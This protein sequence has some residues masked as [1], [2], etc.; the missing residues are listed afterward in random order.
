MDAKG[1]VT[2]PSHCQGNIRESSH[3]QTV[4]GAKVGKQCEFPFIYRN[5]EYT[6][7]TAFAN[8]GVPWCAVKVDSSRR[9]VTGEWG[10][11][12]SGSVCT[13]PAVPPCGCGTVTVAEN[14]CKCGTS[15]CT[16]GQRCVQGQCIAKASTCQEFQQIPMARGLN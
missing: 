13:A 15:S 6:A 7:C 8:S 11:C 2:G 4:S 14:G 10:N 16:T 12:G 9:Y 1:A 5:T 3:C